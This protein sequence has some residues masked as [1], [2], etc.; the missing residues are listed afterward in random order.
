MNLW[1][2]LFMLLVIRCS[3]WECQEGLHCYVKCKGLSKRW[4]S[5][6]CCGGHCGVQQQGCLSHRIGEP[7]AAKRCRGHQ[8]AGKQWAAHAKGG[9]GPGQG[10]SGSCIRPLAGQSCDPAVC[11]ARLLLEPAQQGQCGRH[12]PWR[13]LSSLVV[14]RTAR[15]IQGAEL[16]PWQSVNE[17]FGLHNEFL[18][19]RNGNQLMH[20]HL[21]DGSHLRARHQCPAVPFL[22][23]VLKTLTL[24]TY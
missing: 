18:C 11:S 16:L 6:C 17:C 3:S 19:W 21:E 4:D 8:V 12:R 10:Y 5:Q 7:A 2:S 9:F 22:S 14:L 24:C 13:S 20:G 1:L 23:T 15:S